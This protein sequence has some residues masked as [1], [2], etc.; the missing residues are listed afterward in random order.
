MCSLA[1]LMCSPKK[2]CVHSQKVC[3]SQ[4]NFCFFLWNVY[5]FSQTFEFFYKTFLCIC[6]S[7]FCVC[8]KNIYFFLANCFVCLEKFSCKELCS[9]IKLAFVFKTCCA[10]PRKPLWWKQNEVGGNHISMLLWAN[11]VSWGNAILL[12]RKQSHLIFFSITMTA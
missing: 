1:K 2:L 4:R 10:H 8:S 6:F 12:N 5:I 9:I 3:I 7:F 11:A